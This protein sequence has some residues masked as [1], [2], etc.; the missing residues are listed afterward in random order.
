MLNPLPQL[1]KL[2][3][4][5][6]RD[7]QQQQQH[8]LNWDIKPKSLTREKTEKYNLTVRYSSII[9]GQFERKI[10]FFLISN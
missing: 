5:E 7:Q 10:V 3:E 8:Q 1:W 6:T 2:E 4:P 9:P